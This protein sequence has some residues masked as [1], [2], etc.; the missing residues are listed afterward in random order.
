MRI[1]RRAALA[2]LMATPAFRFAHAADKLQKVTFLFPA[3]A[4]LPAFAPHQIA[5]SR[6]YFKDAGLDVVFEVGH[7][8]AD[9]AKQVAIGNAAVG[10][11]GVETVMLVRGNGLDVRGVA[12]LGGRPIFR[13]AARKA[14]N[15]KD[16]ADLRGKKIGVIDFGDT[17]YYALLGALDAKG[18]PRDAVRIEAVGAAGMTQLM[19][20]KSLDAIMTT[21]DWAYTIEQAGVPLTY[22][23]VYKV[24][25]FFA[26]ALL[27]SDSIIAKQPHVVRG[28]VQAILHGVRDCIKDPASA[29]R[30]FCNAVPQQKGKEAA[31]EAIIRRYDSE[32]YSKAS[33]HDLGL[34]NPQQLR[35]VEQF[36]LK[37]KIMRSPVPIKDLYTNRFVR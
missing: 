33:P 6:G 35:T 31:V 10:G 4:F 25:P 2:G 29:A 28:V 3:P 21:P 9:V 1:T 26:Q 11:G 15:I 16:W 19:I 12:L 30:D 5:K 22:I 20:A 13:L 36:Y 14:A 24:F 17:S 32:V 27:A 7:G 34:F 18:I 8:G 37:T 23:S